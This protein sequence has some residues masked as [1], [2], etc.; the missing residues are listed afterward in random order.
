MLSHLGVVLEL[1][2]CVQI[3]PALGQTV[4]SQCRRAL[5]TFDRAAIDP[6]PVRLAHRAALR[7]APELPDAVVS[8]GVC[9]AE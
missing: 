4:A 7:E 5:N 3:D 9:G 1:N 2:R 8:A 6:T